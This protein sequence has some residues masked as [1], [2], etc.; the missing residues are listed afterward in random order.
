MPRCRLPTRRRSRAVTAT[1]A[2]HKLHVAVG[3]YPDGT[4]GEIWID[5]HRQGS[6]TRHALH[7]FAHLFSVAL[8]RGAPLA[9]LVGRFRGQQ[10]EPCGEV[11]GHDTITEAT[12]LLDYVVRAVEELAKEGP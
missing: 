5:A 4:I 7:A 1:V 9:E 2:G 3:F 10:F 12:S 6:F 11:R 8:Q